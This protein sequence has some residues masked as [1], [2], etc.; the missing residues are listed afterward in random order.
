MP[1]LI[2]RKRTESDEY[3]LFAR[4]RQAANDKGRELGVRPEGRLARG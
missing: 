2:L 3:E 1:Q 4:A